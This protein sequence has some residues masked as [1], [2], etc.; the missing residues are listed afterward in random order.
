MAL[1]SLLT[2]LPEDENDRNR[3]TF[4]HS[5]EH[6]AIINAVRAQ[7]GVSLV[8][9]LLDPFEPAAEET[10]LMSHQQAHDQ[11]NDVL[12][13]PG[14]DLQSYDFK[15]P[16]GRKELAFLHFREHQA[17]NAALALG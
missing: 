11:F 16:Q 15:T 1:F 4:S 7:K 17:A 5:T 9:F 8:E 12:G 13:L 2:W 6:L 10:W 14:S 3:W